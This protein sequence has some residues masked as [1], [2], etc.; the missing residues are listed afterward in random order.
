MAENET[1]TTLIDPHG[2]VILECTNDDDSPNLGLPVFKAIF[3]S[4]FKESLS[5]RPAFEKQSIPLPND[6]LE[7][8]TIL[9]NILHHRTFEVP[10][11]LAI[12][13]LENLGVICDK[14]DCTRVFEI[15]STMWLNPWIES[16]PSGDLNKLLLV[17]FMLNN[18]YAFSRFSWEII[19]VHV[20][21]FMDLP[22]V[23]DHPLVRCDILEEF[24]VRKTEMMLKLAKMI[25]SPI[26]CV[27]GKVRAS[28]CSSVAQFIA[29]Y[30][31][32][33][34]GRDLWPINE[35]LQKGTISRALRQI[36][37]FP[38]STFNAAC[39]YACIPCTDGIPNVRQGL[40]DGK[41]KFFGTKIGACLD[42]IKTEE[43]SLQKGEYRIKHQ[44]ERK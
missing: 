33:L 4:R 2:N 6:D 36:D 30:L 37:S 44:Y 21:Q 9:C 43:E 35:M 13:R 1:T 39:K 18:P 25:E 8:F 16:H 15:W 22:G 32:N 19:S 12:D 34:Q 24:R 14:Y 29:N 26:A 7:A 27:L 41:K 40:L 5:N 17:A 28:P 3:N 11:E 10:K 42:C 38:D 23:S 31:C 20:G